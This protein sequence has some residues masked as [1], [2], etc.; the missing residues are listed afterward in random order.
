MI[1]RNLENNIPKEC[2]KFIYIL[3]NVKDHAHPWAWSHNQNKQQ[4]QQILKRPPFPLGH[5]ICVA[6]KTESENRK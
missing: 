3:G 4:Q 5:K 2:S 6:V 1:K